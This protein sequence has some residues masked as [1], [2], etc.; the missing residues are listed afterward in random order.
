MTYC[1]TKASA[2][3]FAEANLCKWLDGMVVNYTIADKL[4]QFTDE[5]YKD[6]VEESWAPWLAES[7]LRIRYVDGSSR[8]PEDYPNVIF[9]IRPIDGQFGILAEAELPCGNVNS[10]SQRRIWFDTNDRWANATNPPARFLDLIEVARH[11]IGHVIGIP[12][13]TSTNALMNPT[14]QGNRNLRPA[15]IAEAV[16]RYGDPSQTPLPPGQGTPDFCENLL[17][18]FFRGEALEDATKG[19]AYLRKA[20]NKRGV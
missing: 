4:P 17:R 5:E 18:N 10:R 16:R 11:E 14:V 19:W 15:D 9:T 3:A 6:A 2:L 20:L 1:A 12:H 8:N 7:G 13:I